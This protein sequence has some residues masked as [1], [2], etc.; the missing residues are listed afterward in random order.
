MLTKGFDCSLFG[1]IT[2]GVPIR[3]DF[4]V[5]GGARQ[6]DGHCVRD[7]PM[8]QADLVAHVLYDTLERAGCLVSPIGR[9][10]GDLQVKEAW[11]R[12]MGWEWERCLWGRLAEHCG[13]R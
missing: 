10:L 8:V 2:C 11:Q 5:C 3:E 13:L 7:W 9:S 1:V 12:Q 6:R 4:V